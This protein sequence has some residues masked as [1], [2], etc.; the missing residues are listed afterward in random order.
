M[1]QLNDPD[2][3]VSVTLIYALCLLLKGE[4]TKNQDDVSK[5]MLILHGLADQHS[6]ILANHWIAHYHFTG[7]SFKTNIADRN[8]DLAVD[9]YSRTLAIIKTYNSYPPFI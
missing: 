8:L 4:V 5:G 9:Y 7:G 2:P 6:N 3:Y 1:E